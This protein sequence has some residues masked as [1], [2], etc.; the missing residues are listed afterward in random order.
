MTAIIGL[1]AAI[2]TTTSFLPQ[3]LLVIR[4]RNTSGIS[5]VMY[6]MFTTGVAGWLIYGLLIGSMPVIV[7]NMVTLA[8]AASILVMK[9]S[10][11]R[12]DRRL[13]LAE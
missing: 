9:I 6:A 1:L 4:T 7:A 13:R 3:A 12:R 10:H 11:L 8:L 5:L 2:L